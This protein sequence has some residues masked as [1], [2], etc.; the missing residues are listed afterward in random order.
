MQPREKILAGVLAAVVGFWF[1][2]PVFNAMFI[3]PLTSRTDEITT[4][5]AS[6]GRLQIRK[7][8]LLRD[9]T[10]L[11]EW[12]AESLPPDALDAEREYPKWLYALAELCGWEEIGIVAGGRNT[13][14]SS[15]TGVPITLNAESTLDGINRF[16]SLMETSDLLQRISM[17][18]IECPYPEGNPIMTVNVTLEGLALTDAA[19]RSRLFP[20]T[21]LA[22][23]LSETDETVNVDSFAGFPE[24]TPFRVR[25][26]NE[27]IDVVGMDGNNWR[28]ERGAAGT[29]PAEHS[30]SD[31]V[32]LLP[33]QD[34]VAS[35]SEQLSLVIDRIFV[36]PRPGFVGRAE[37]AELPVAIRG[38][39]FASRLEVD[40]WNS[41]EGTPRFR[42]LSEAPEGLQFSPSSGE[43]NWELGDD[44]ELAT[45][46]L[47]VAAYGLDSDVPVL[48]DTVSLVV[49]RPNRP[50]RISAPREIDAWLGRPLTLA[51]EFEDADLPE[52]ELFFSLDGDIPEGASFDSRTGE[53]SWTPL[54]TEDLGE[55]ELDLTVTDSGTPPESDTVRLVFN[56]RDD[57]AL[58]TF[59]VGTIIQGERQEAWLFDRVREDDQLRLL[60]LQEGESFHIADMEGT[61]EEIRVAS[62]DIRFEGALYELPVGKNLR[63]WQL[64]EQ[65]EDNATSTTPAV[66]D[67]PESE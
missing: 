55:L 62:I 46:D 18:N 44:A 20:D 19:G 50:P 37:F 27:L 6:V 53:F 66:S 65:V 16:L 24:A 36:L 29:F 30:A 22:E 7:A 17:L 57:N 2:R 63:E 21:L 4:L 52:D 23:E 43:L 59:L 8:E 60:K 10:Q 3:E 38:E 12:Q 42:L 33:S 47:E 34:E 26:N 51:P 11:A 13:R 40:N 25:V 1:L 61:I 58:Y 41:D 31:I 56:R 5:E 49:R 28:V 15:F 64:I 54:V 39:T 9:T 32:E 48:E 35:S 14:Q 45:Y 67:A